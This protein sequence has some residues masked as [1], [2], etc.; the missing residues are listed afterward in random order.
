ML[1]LTLFQLPNINLLYDYHK[2]LKF[3]KGMGYIVIEQFYDFVYEEYSSWVSPYIERFFALIKKESS[4]RVTFLEFL[5]AA[6][7]YCLFT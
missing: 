3:F 6:S 1:L 7:V 5:P 2:T 4:D